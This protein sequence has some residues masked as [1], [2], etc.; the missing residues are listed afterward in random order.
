MSGI[1]LTFGFDDGPIRRHL[2]RLALLDARGFESVRR[3]IGEYFVA[4]VQDNLDG[5][6]LAD[7]APMP[8]SK[9]AIARRGKTLIDKGHL[10]DSYVHQLVPG[11]VEVG[12][13]L[14]YAAIHHFGGET[15]RKA[16]R[17]TMQARPV[18][19]VHERQERELG[20]FLIAE[21]RKTQGG[22]A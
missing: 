19:G 12:S 20:D 4:E 1:A 15:G 3:E 13:A 18:L 2:A 9:A 8:Q 14:V 6:K 17:F 7:G 22:A 21:I 11:G 5:Q 10:R 16:H